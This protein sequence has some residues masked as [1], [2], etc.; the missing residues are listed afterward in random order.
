MSDDEFTRSLVME[1]L[2]AR[3]PRQEDT[4]VLRNTSRDPRLTQDAKADLNQ[5]IMR[6][7]VSTRQALDNLPETLVQA[8]A[9][10]D[11]AAGRELEDDPLPIPSAASMRRHLLWLDDAMDCLLRDDLQK[12]REAGITTVSRV[13]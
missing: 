1:V 13:L 11:K 12:A 6:L 9:L 10:L 2:E 3:A 7:A 8:Q 4:S 5:S